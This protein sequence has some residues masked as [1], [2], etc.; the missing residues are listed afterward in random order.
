MS[1]VLVIGMTQWNLLQDQWEVSPTMEPF[2]R[3]LLR[4]VQ[5]RTRVVRGWDQEGP[6]FAPRPPVTANTNPI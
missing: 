5:A 1:Q 4:K 2:G 6:G 3:S